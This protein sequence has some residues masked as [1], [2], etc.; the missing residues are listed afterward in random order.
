MNETR[1]SAAGGFAMAALLVA[2]VPLDASA[3]GSLVTYPRAGQSAEQQRQDRFECHEFAVESTGFDPQFESQ[4][5]ARS[6]A[7]LA[8]QSNTGGPDPNQGGTVR[9]AAR[10]AALG[11]LGG[12]IGGNAGRGAAIGAGTGALFGTGRRQS[13][14]NER[15]SWEREQARQRQQESNRLQAEFDQGK[16]AYERAFTVCM[17]AR[18]YEVL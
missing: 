16:D 8:T 3:Q 1:R 17:R 18:D 9:G 2:S 4:F 12:A 15:A 5:L 13:A 7:Q 6:Q 11:A 14:Q 10:G